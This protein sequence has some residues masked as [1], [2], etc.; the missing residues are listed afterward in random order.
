MGVPSLVANVTPYKEVIHSESTK[1][2]RAMS[3]KNDEEFSFNLEEMLTRSRLRGDIGRNARQFVE[4]HYSA[5]EWAGKIVDIYSTL[6][7]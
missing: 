4:K 5:K 6:S 3:Y 7:A 1:D 2:R